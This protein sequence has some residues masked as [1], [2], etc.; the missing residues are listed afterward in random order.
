MVYPTAATLNDPPW[1]TIKPGRVAEGLAGRGR[2]TAA[3]AITWVSYGMPVPLSRWSV[4]I[5]GVPEH[6]PP[7]PASDIA[8]DLFAGSGSLG[9]LIDRAKYVD[10]LTISAAA[11]GDTGHA[12]HPYGSGPDATPLGAVVKGVQNN[13]LG[14]ALAYGKSLDQAATLVPA[15]RTARLILQRVSEAGHVLVYGTPL[16]SAGRVAKPHGRVTPWTLGPR[17][18]FT[19]CGVIAHETD[20]A[21]W[22]NIRFDAETLATV[23]PPGPIQE[24]DNGF[25]NPSSAAKEWQVETLNQSYK[26]Q[27]GR[28]RNKL[29]PL[30]RKLYNRLREI[31][32][33]TPGKI[34]IQTQ[35][36]RAA[37]KIYKNGVPEPRTLLKWIRRWDSED[38]VQTA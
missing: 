3:E 22:S 13:D 32:P 16:T 37:A 21:L 28:P 35:L 9:G 25:F 11:H 18:Y 31:G 7:I 20:G 24:V 27:G 5:F 38:L 34:S 12:L 17:S 36:S 19:P 15:L 26:S 23:F 14:P 29:E 6:L 33:F 4:E 2:V 10:F 8:I 1:W 30:I